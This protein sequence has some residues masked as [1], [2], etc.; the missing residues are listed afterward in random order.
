MD[1][2]QGVQYNFE[3][4]INVEIHS[5]FSSFRR[6]SLENNFESASDKKKSVTTKDPNPRNKGTTNSSGVQQGKTPVHK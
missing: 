6:Y 5:N 1:S 4:I 3:G 2:Y